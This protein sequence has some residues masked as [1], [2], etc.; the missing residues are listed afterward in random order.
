MFRKLW[1]E[2]NIRIRAHTHIYRGITSSISCFLGRIIER[3]QTR[4]I[5]SQPRRRLLRLP[6]ERING[7]SA[8][9][10]TLETL[11]SQSWLL[12]GYRWATW[13]TQ[14]YRWVLQS[15]Y[16]GVVLVFLFLFLFHVKNCVKD[17]Y[18]VCKEYFLVSRKKD[19][20]AYCIIMWL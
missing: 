14:V 20:M 19:E 13:K 5:F 2:M 15:I 10:R 1:L 17:N 7:C 6:S 16:S 9:A 11:R 18:C 4:S 12:S 3:T 8:T